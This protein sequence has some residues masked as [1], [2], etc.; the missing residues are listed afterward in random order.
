MV[1]PHFP[2]IGVELGLDRQGIG[3]IIQSAGRLG[4]ST[5][6]NNH[7]G[8]TRNQE[9]PHCTK[10]LPV[11]GILYPVSQEIKKTMIPGAWRDVEKKSIG[12]YNI[13][14]SFVVYLSAPST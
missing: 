9:E 4:D 8:N 1:V 10:L 13:S 2:E 12:P 7:P 3:K 11:D 5:G 6:S 14:A